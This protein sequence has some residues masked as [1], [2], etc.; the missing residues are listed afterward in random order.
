MISIAEQQQE[1]CA[2]HAAD[3]GLD[4]ESRWGQNRD[5]WSRNEM[6]NGLTL[7]GA[8]LS[9]TVEVLAGKTRNG[10]TLPGATLSETVEVRAGKTRTV[11]FL[12]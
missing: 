10:L 5:G 3:A 4:A 1:E 8:T 6:S 11:T 12:H 7:P 2:R 9:E